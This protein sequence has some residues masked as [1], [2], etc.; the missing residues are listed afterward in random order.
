MSEQTTT[1]ENQNIA[2]DIN[3]GPPQ[4]GEEVAIEIEPNT[5][6]T[7]NVGLLN[8]LRN[9]ISVVSDRGAIKAQEMYAVGMVYNSLTEVIGTVVKPA[10]PSQEPQ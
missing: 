9:I 2:M 4:K 7:V 8:N 5:P 1:N 6:V 3:E 10:K